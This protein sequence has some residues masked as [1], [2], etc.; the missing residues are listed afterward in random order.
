MVGDLCEVEVGDE[1]V[2]GH[3]FDEALGDEEAVRDGDAH[4]ECERE[5]EPSEDGLEGEE[6]PE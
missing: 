1:F 2:D 3:F 4:E 6:G 5:E